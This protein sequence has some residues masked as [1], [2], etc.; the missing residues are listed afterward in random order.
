[1]IQVMVA[2]APDS[3]TLGSVAAGPVEDMMGGEYL[4]LMQ[5]EAESSPRFRI[6]L[7]MTNG[8]PKE[9]EPFADRISDFEVLPPI[10]PIAVTPEEIE[11]MTAYFHL[12]DIGWADLLFGEL[13][14]DNPTEAWF[15]L[16][17]LLDKAEKIPDLLEDVF[18][19]AVSQFISANFTAYRSELTALAMGNEALRERFMKTKHPWTADSEGWASMIRELNSK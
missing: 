19:H 14:R 8:L 11:L 7:G 10:Q 3:G 2:Y 15:M 5:R 13:N 18:V 17:L 4:M 9:L 16:Q 6:A 12:S 1:M